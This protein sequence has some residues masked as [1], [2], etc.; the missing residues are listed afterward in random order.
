MINLG[1]IVNTVQ[2]NCH[3]S[4]A[5]YARN[6]SM[7]IFLLK[8]RE[9][10]RWEY[11]IPLSQPIPKKEIGEWLIER[12]LEWDEL[13]E[14]NYQPLPLENGL[15]DPFD[16]EAINKELLPQGYV[17]SSGIGL[18]HKPHFFLGQI[19]KV[20]R[21]EDMTIY[22]SS[23]E[24]AR[25][26]VAPPAMSIGKKIFIRQESIRRFIWE[27]IEEWQ[28][29]KNPQVPMAKVINCYPSDISSESLLDEVTTLET[30]SM[31]L[32]EIGEVEAGKLLG[33]DW[34]QMIT[35]L[36]RSKAEFL[37]RAVRDHL[38][39]CIST[40]PRLLSSQKI[41]SLHF[42]FAN[43]SGIRKT[44][45]PEAVEAYQVW[46]DT[47][48]TKV[49][50]EIIAQGKNHWLEKAQQIL[51][52]YRAEQNKLENAIEKLLSYSRNSGVESTAQKLN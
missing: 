48:N 6:Y 11:D 2:K 22:V 27:K 37:V 13:T 21:H 45:F 9:Y 25:D 50:E 16:F 30:E 19:S 49:L 44:L 28:W 20:E 40:L 39:D 41:S 26:L 35:S 23:C 32:H 24:H 42:Y 3:V 8:M 15:V 38:A 46:I 1:Q 12:E 33:Q 34:E 18:F 14:E 47:G 7:C 31:I 29:K 36:S 5:I 43:F 10:F 17:Y 52:L 4:D 51:E